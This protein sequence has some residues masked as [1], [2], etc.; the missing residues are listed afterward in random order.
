MIL[1][2]ALDIYKRVVEACIIDEAGR[3]VRRERFDLTVEKLTEFRRMRLGREAKVVIE[4]TTNTWAAVRLLKPHVGEVVVSN[5]LLTKAIAQAKI[6]TDKVDALVLAEVTRCDFL[7]RV[8]EPDEA[9]QELRRLW[10]RSGLVADRTAVKNRLH[11]VLAQRLLLPPSELFSKTGQAWLS[12][13]TL[14]GEGRQ[15]IDSDLALLAGIEREIAVL[16]QLMATK[17]WRPRVKLLMTLPGVDVTAAQTLLAALGDNTRFRDR[18]HAAGYLG[19][20]SSTRQS[21][22]RCY[23]G[24]I[25]KAGNGHRVGCWCRR[26]ADGEAASGTVGGILPAG[27]E[28]EELQR[29]GGGNSAEAGGDCL[30]H[31]QG[32]PTVSLRAAGTDQSEVATTAGPGDGRAAQE[33]SGEGDAAAGPTRADADGQVAATGLRRR[34]SAGH[35]AAAGRRGPH[36]DR[37]RHASVCRFAQGAERVPRT[38]RQQPKPSTTQPEGERQTG[39]WFSPQNSLSFP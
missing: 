29:G 26:R 21:A 9:T 25:T 19:L 28:E 2:C 39:A 23:H 34:R 5:P 15:F 1:D 20:A 35:D 13:L 27:G 22:D 24:P 38:K 14:D 3:I 8:W 17:G 18:D 12:D 7:P 11:S 16:E 6:K 32:E 4:A 37:E 30:A 31:A 10:R 36:R 33:R